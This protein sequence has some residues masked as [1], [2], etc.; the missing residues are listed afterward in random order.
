[1]SHHF[2]IHP[3]SAL[4]RFRRCT[5]SHQPP[6][7]PQPSPLAIA[8]NNPYRRWCSAPPFLFA[9]PQFTNGL[10]LGSP[11]RLSLA[12]SAPWGSP[13]GP[14]PDC[15]LHPATFPRSW[16]PT[17]L[18]FALS[19][20]PASVAG[21]QP[22]CRLTCPPLGPGRWSPISTSPEPHPVCHP[23]RQTPLAW[24]RLLSSALGALLLPTF[25][26]VRSWCP[27]LLSHGDIESN[28]GPDFGSQYSG[29][30]NCGQTGHTSKQCTRPYHCAHC[31]HSGHIISF[32]RQLLGKGKQRPPK[33]KR[34]PPQHAPRHTTNTRHLPTPPPPYSTYD[35]PAA[36]PLS[37][38]PPRPGS[39]TGPITATG[40]RFRVLMPKDLT[41]PFGPAYPPSP[42]HRPVSPIPT[43]TP[44]RPSSPQ[45]VPQGPPHRH[46]PAVPHKR[47]RRHPRRTPLSPPP[48]LPRA[49]TL[50][51]LA[52]T[53][54]HP[55]LRPPSTTTHQTRC[56]VPP[57]TP[58]TP[59]P[60]H[61]PPAPLQLTPRP[62]PHPPCL[63]HPG[64]NPSCRPGP[65]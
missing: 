14:L 19:S 36:P 29:C 58:P 40:V 11:T 16:S 32:C 15:R 62:P 38:C 44:K 43:P 26:T 10:A 2:A 33:N 21:P 64:A 53:R 12:P 28:P 20:P 35:F 23:F 56:N 6:P 5:I 42:Q 52:M 48:P 39:P 13:S 7:S 49:S 65:S 1:M 25:A 18:S 61:H 45:P 59:N 17:S 22:A 9:P 46:D 63:L 57:A 55:S 3:G 54:P 27:D 31:G 47:H 41:Y 37:G 50:S 60:R 8:S 24:R 51:S 4:V 30:L 34:P